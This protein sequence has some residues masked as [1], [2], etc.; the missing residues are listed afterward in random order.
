MG[1]TDAQNHTYQIG[2][3]KGLLYS[4]WNYMQYFVITYNGKELNTKNMCVCMCVY[5]TESFYYVPETHTIVNQL[6]FN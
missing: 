4:T 5:V 3:Q 1:L 6:Y 2:K